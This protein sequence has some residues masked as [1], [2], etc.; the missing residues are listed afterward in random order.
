[1]IKSLFGVF[2]FFVSIL[3]SSLFYPRV[4]FFIKNKTPFYNMFNEN[5]KQTINLSK[6]INLDL[7]AQSV[8]N[9]IIQDS[10]SS[11]NISQKLVSNVQ[12]PSSIKQKFLNINGAQLGKILKLD[13]LENFLSGG[14]SNIL[15]NILAMILT[16][17]LLNV[18]LT[19]IAKTLDLI[20]FLPF[21]SSANK[22]GGLA[23]GLLN[24]TISL[25]VTCMALSLFI[26]NPNL[27]FL[28]SAMSGSKLAIKFYNKNFILQFLALFMPVLKLKK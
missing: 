12:I 13:A 17:T 24:G 7:I 16:F 3:G 5:I 14:I 4:A 20:S 18:S 10:T 11:I 8:K 22:L 23:I 1:L 26:E 19:V 9:N 15:L 27:R 6:R 21:L 28:K 2:S 25:W